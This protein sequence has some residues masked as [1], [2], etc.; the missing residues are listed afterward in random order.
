[1]IVA[2]VVGSIAV[3]DYPHDTGELMDFETT[4]SL[5]ETDMALADVYST[6]MTCEAL[7][8]MNDSD[9]E[10]LFNH[11]RAAFLAGQADVIERIRPAFTDWVA[12][13]AQAIDGQAA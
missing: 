1:L 3:N 13:F 11:L 8:E 6:L 2:Y 10:V 4:M 5:M 12:K 9:R 7:T